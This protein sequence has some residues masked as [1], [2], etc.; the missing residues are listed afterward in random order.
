LEILSINNTRRENEVTFDHEATVKRNLPKVSAV[1]AVDL[2]DV[3]SVLLNVYEGIQSLTV[4]I[5]TI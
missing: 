5:I 4:F 2:P 3:T 1:I